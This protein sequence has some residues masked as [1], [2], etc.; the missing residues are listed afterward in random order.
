M[1][2]KAKVLSQGVNFRMT[3]ALSRCLPYLMLG[4]PSKRAS[5]AP[6]YCRRKVERAARQ[7]NRGVVSSRS[8]ANYVA[9]KRRIQWFGHKP[10]QGHG[11]W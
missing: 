11:V 4:T 1:N 7:D 8:F 5:L 6:F 3:E 9:E 10:G 2:L